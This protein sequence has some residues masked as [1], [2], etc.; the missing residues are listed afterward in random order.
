MDVSAREALSL[1]AALRSAS[2]PEGPVALS[3]SYLR[4]V[5]RVGALPAN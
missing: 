5:A 2:L 3:P 1:L 4:R